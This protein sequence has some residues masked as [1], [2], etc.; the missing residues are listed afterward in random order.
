VIVGNSGKVIKLEIV[1]INRKNFLNLLFDVIIYNGVKFT[2]ISNRC[3]KRIDYANPTIA[4]F[5]FVARNY[6]KKCKR[7]NFRYLI[8]SKPRKIG[9]DLVT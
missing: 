2:R 8:K 5:A 3:S 7:L 6:E 1:D 4:P 9:N